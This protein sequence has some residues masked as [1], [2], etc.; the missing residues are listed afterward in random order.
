[1]AE[2]PAM[3]PH[4]ELEILAGVEPAAAAGAA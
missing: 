2:P 3:E 1:M 4:V